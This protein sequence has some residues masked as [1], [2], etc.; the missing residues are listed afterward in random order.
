MCRRRTACQAASVSGGWLM[1][2]YL[3]SVL[4]PKGTRS[5]SAQTVTRLR[6]VHG[7]PP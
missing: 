1:D 4:Y 6:S 5:L 7:T 3:S 2:R